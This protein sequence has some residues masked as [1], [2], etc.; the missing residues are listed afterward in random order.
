MECAS[1]WQGIIDALTV[2]V[3]VIAIGMGMALLAW[4]T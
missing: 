2:I 3:W 4:M 1:D